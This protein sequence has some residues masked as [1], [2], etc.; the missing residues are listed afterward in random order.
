MQAAS[1]A[2][3]ARAG[4]ADDAGAP[5]PDRE[6]GV[7]EARVARLIASLPPEEVSADLRAL[8]EAHTLVRAGADALMDAAAALPALLQGVV[9]LFRGLALKDTVC[10]SAGFSFNASGILRAI[11][12][13]GGEPDVIGGRPELD[14][15]RSALLQSEADC[16]LAGFV[17][18]EARGE[19]LGP[20]A[21]KIERVG[22][23]LKSVAAYWCRPGL[24]QAAAA[25]LGALGVRG[26]EGVSADVVA[27]LLQAHTAARMSVRGRPV[28]ALMEQT[29][30]AYPLA[31]STAANLALGL[32]TTDPTLAYATALRAL[33]RA[34]A[35]LPNKTECDHR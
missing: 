21:E 24:A 18:A 14:L 7:Y 19:A 23:S 32:L 20:L 13:A 26:G 22:A 28:W 25:R 11:R 30:A 31:L 9:D 12:E 1:S 16:S 17:Q 34:D 27:V 6:P 4:A 2:G 10:G 5:P 35:A 8:S 33:Q 3:G 29:C 15:L